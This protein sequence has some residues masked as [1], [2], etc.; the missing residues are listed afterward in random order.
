MSI[1]KN[2]IQIGSYIGDTKNDPLFETIDSFTRLFLI[3]PVP[4]YFEQLKKNYAKTYPDYYSNMV[5][6]NKAVTTR[7]NDW[8]EMHVPSLSNDLSKFPYWVPQLASIRSDHIKKHIR[9]NPTNGLDRLVMEKIQVPT[10]TLK[11]ILT[12]YQIKSIHTLQVDTEGYDYNILMDYDFS[13]Q[14]YQILFEYTHMN[15]D[16]YQKLENKLDSLGYTFDSID[17]EN[18]C[19]RIDK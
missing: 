13:I 7:D 18:I 10:I 16:Q 1:F 2:V 4:S 9:L 15:E 17:H 11:T 12:N 19:F 14:P 6:I 5:F 8:V 3:E